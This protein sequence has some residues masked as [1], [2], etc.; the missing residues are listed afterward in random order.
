MSLT[1][2]PYLR[3][4]I[5]DA[6]LTNTMHRFPRLEH[7]RLEC[8][9]K[10]DINISESS[11]LKDIHAMKNDSRLGFDAPIKYSK[12]NNGNLLTD[13]SKDILST[14]YG[15]ASYPF[16]LKVGTKDISY[17]YDANDRRVFKASSQAH[18]IIQTSEYY[19]YDDRGNLKEEKF[20]EYMDLSNDDTSNEIL[21]DVTMN[22]EWTVTG[23]VSRIEKLIYDNSSLVGIEEIS[24]S[25][26]A[27]DQRIQK[28]HKQHAGVDGVLI[29]QESYPYTL[30]E[31]NTTYYVLD[32]SGNQMAMYEKTYTQEMEADN[33]TPL[34]TFTATINLKEQPIYGSS[35]V[36]ENI[37]IREI[38]TLT[39]IEPNA[40][41]E[42]LVFASLKDGLTT[43]SEY[44]NWIT[45]ANSTT[46]VSGGLD[47][48]CQCKVKKLGYD[49][50]ED[51]Y[52]INPNSDELVEFL[53]ISDNGLAIAENLSGE[54]QF[55]AVLVKKYLGGSDA[56]L[57]YDIEGNLMKGVDAIKDVDM[58]S[59]PI[60]L[61]VPG[62]NNKYGLVTLSTS[63]NPIYHVIDMD[64]S[65]YG[66]LDPMG[67]IVEVNQPMVTTIPPD[68]TDL[69]VQY[70]WHFTGYEDHVSE[71][72]IVYTS[73][74][75]PATSTE[76]KTE[77]IALKFDSDLSSLPEEHVLYELEGCGDTKKGE[78]QIS[79]DGDKLVWYQ[80]GKNI[81][82]FDHRQVDIY[83]FGL[84]VDKIS[85]SG[86][87]ERV[88]TGGAGNA[89][90][91]MV[92]FTS[93]NQELVYS[94]RG[95]Y[96]SEQESLSSNTVWK[97]EPTTPEAILSINPISPNAAYL[98]SQIRR[99]KDG[100][101]Y[102]PNMGSSIETIHTYKQGSEVGLYDIGFT[103][104]DYV[105]NSSIPTQVY[106]VYGESQKPESYSRLIGKKV[107]EITD[108]LGN[109]R[110]VLSD[111]KLVEPTSLGTVENGNLNEI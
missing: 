54:T 37:N 106:K 67:E 58:E 83:T 57:V 79:P 24:L 92:E 34:S 68:D 108:H 42:P 49:E 89:G 21:H 45:S 11:I 33:T 22:I 26:D 76:G 52:I 94:Q 90:R 66:N 4:T 82:A 96:G 53:G 17:L 64:R 84:N 20:M 44:Q 60:I 98:Y 100:R 87:I 3:Y 2:I 75:T 14:T 48:I 77:I 71:F 91:G 97:V 7:L 81:A 41:G 16:Q 78:L 103:E 46:T 104:E 110:I 35:R 23:K 61:K 43:V 65:G 86:D 18:P 80:H 102:M 63:G 72:S 51:E 10:L 28:V 55:Y 8:E 32:A 109:V 40:S 6:C 39:G 19:L 59:K 56:C 12:S 73:R 25:Y 88:E 70:G 62:S 74:Y 13:D 1:K 99:G 31:I 95:L 38:A 30:G 36:G 50:T 85:P 101:L 111:R 107:Y 105:Y 15:R 27:M 29:V 47:Q 93:N 69:A 9:R 5:I